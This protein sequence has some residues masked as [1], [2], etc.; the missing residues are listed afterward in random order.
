MRLLSQ[1]IGQDLAAT[2]RHEQQTVYVGDLYERA[3][4]LLTG[5][6]EHRYY[7]HGALLGH[8]GLTGS[9]ATYALRR[10]EKRT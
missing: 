7:V 3:T 5:A 8:G 6:A 1:L 9:P 2:V 10:R 4:D